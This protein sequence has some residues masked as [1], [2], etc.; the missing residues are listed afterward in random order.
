MNVTVIVCMCI[1]SACMH[2]N[3]TVYIDKLR[4]TY[5]PATD[6]CSLLAHVTHV[7]EPVSTAA[8]TK[9]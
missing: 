2:K 9:N 5:I 3:V 7:C 8:V 4:W 6:G 1:I